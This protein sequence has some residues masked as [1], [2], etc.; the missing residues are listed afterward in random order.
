MRIA[1]AYAKGYGEARNTIYLLLQRLCLLNSLGKR[2]VK[3][4]AFFGR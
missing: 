2:K 1:P 3:S 4:S